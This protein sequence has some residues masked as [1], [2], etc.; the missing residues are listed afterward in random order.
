MPTTAK[1]GAT[2]EDLCALPENVVG[3]I[4]HGDLTATPRPSARHGIAASVLGSEILGPFQLGKGGP[5]GWWIIDEPEL[6]LSPHVLVPDIAGWRKERMP[7]PPEG[8]AIET[9]PD[10]ICEVLSE[11]TVQTDR[12]RKMPL[13]AELGVMHLWLVDPEAR[14]LEVF[15]R[16]ESRWLLLSAHAGDERVRAEPFGEIELE[17]ALLWS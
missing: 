2:Y 13:Y 12:I 15:R 1:G 17:L 3:E 8:H 4:I 10:W 6:H 14:T 7:V 11:R 5:G 16:E 9:V